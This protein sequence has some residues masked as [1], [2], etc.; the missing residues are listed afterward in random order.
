MNVGEKWVR[1][2]CDGNARHIQVINPATGERIPG[3][4]NVKFSLCNEDGRLKQP[5][6]VTLELYARVDVVGA[7]EVLPKEWP[8]DDGRAAE[9][10][11]DVKQVKE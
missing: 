5:A 10:P 7:L 2:I 1:V 3:I 8:I 9:F 6:R 4:I 11:D